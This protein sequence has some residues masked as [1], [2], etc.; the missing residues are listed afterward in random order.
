MQ[1][2]QLHAFLAVATHL[3]FRRAAA[4][5]YLSQG[6]LS[7]QIQALERELGVQLFDRDRSGTRLTRDGLDLVAVARSA[8]AAVAEVE[9][10]A[11]RSPRFRR[12]FVVGAADFGARG[13]TWPLLCTFHDARPDLELTVLHVS[14]KDALGRLRTGVI[15]VLL[16]VGPFGATDGWATD[17]ALLPVA[18]VLPA[19]HPFAGADV[20][21]TDWIADRLSIRPPIGL[22]TA[23][24]DFWSMRRWGGPPLDR[25]DFVDP[26]LQVADLP[27][28]IAAEGRVSL[29]PSGVPTSPDVV[30]K[31]L[32]TPIDAPLQILAR[33]DAHPDVREFV[34]IATRLATAS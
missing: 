19:H 4:S 6:A 33:W 17:I 25:L 5:L 1:I 34:S 16:A 11:R 8:V 21:A 26:D 27:G 2:N 32:T 7:A 14:F 15:D 24:V 13:L 18:A 3:N 28:M 22:G 12:R 23:W 20:V 30:L 29:W 9:L 31:P 10:A